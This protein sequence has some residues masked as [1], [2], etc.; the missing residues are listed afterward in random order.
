M[1][2]PMAYCRYIRTQNKM[3]KQKV[4][5]GIPKI[6]VNEP[7]LSETVLAK[8]CYHTT[9]SCFNYRRKCITLTLR[10]VDAGRI[11]VYVLALLR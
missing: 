6:G 2:N 3:S 1:K 9:G 5:D 10:F 11:P 7:R 4:K 8:N